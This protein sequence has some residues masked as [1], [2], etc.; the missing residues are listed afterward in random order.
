MNLVKPMANGC[1][2]RNQNIGY[3]YTN[4]PFHV[5]ES[6]LLTSIV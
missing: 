4:P 6:I 1:W 3:S 2:K 5:I